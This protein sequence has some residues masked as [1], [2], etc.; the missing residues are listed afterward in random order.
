MVYKP[1][2][3]FLFTFDDQKYV[4]L[5]ELHHQEMLLTEFWI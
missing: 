1:I 4:N 3:L 2:C 5:P